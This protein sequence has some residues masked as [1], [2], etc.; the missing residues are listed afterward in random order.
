MRG[1]L[2]LLAAGDASAYLS[3]LAAARLWERAAWRRAFATAE[4]MAAIAEAATAALNGVALTREE[5]A[6]EII[7]L[8]GDPS[9]GEKLSSGW[10]AVLKPEQ[11]PWA[12]VLIGVP[13]FVSRRDRCPLWRGRVAVWNALLACRR[14]Q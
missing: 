11:S 7:T 5:L 1:T 3:L 12:R 2:H 14:L 13:G 4:Q 10:G 8:T 9:L 6:A